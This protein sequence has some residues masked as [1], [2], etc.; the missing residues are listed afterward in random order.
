V[1]HARLG[2][3]VYVVIGADEAISNG[4]FGVDVHVEVIGLPGGN[5]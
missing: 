3:D 4:H 5:P 1:I 2:D